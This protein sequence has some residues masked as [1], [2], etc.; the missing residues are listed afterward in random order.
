MPRAGHVGGRS[1]V[2]VYASAHEPGAGLNEHIAWG[3]RSKETVVVGRN[4]VQHHAGRERRHEPRGQTHG[5][6]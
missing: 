1:L 6:R 4:S 2:Q 3:L 5:Y